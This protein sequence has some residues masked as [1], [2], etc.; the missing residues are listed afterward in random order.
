M[1]NKKFNFVFVISIIILLIY[2]YIVFM[3]IVYWKDGDIVQGIICSVALIAVTLACII[4]MCRAKASRWKT[5]GNVVQIVCGIIMLAVLA[6]STM[7]FAHFIN[8]VVKQKEITATFEK[9][10]QYG[11]QS[12]VAYNNYVKEREAKTRDYLNAVDAGHGVSNPSEYQEI[13]GLP[14]SDSNTAKIDRMI[15]SLHTILLPDS[16]THANDEALQNLETGAKMSVWNIALPQYINS[17]DQMVRTNVAT[18]SNLSKK[19]HGYKGDNNYP[20]FAYQQY[21]DQNAQLKEMLTHMSMPSVISIIAALLCFAFM[22]LPYYLVDRDLA[23]GTSG[24]RSPLATPPTTRPN[25]TQRR[26]RLT[27]RDQRN[28]Q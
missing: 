6:L 10:H 20:P 18:F 13:F 22:L 4:I 23:Q 24:K 17:I 7:P 27:E 21:T 2:S 5:T 11:S 3:G 25:G 1:S 28:N 26:S 14:G 16:V 15:N 8:L 19:A 9:A 12:V